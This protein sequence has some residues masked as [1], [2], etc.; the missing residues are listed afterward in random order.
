MLVDAI[1]EH[2]QEL[3]KIEFSKPEIVTT[4]SIQFRPNKY[5]QS[6]IWWLGFESGL[7]GKT[8]PSMSKG[9]GSREK[10]RYECLVPDS[11]AVS[12]INRAI[13]WA[14]PSISDDIWR[15]ICKRYRHEKSPYKPPYVDPEKSE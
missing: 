2:C 8:A 5:Q 11:V 12:E 1:I 13:A 3:T 4:K 9:E 10:V 6:Y 15:G 7:I 14:M